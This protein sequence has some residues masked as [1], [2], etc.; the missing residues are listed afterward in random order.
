MLLGMNPE[1]L[2]LFEISTIDFQKLRGTK[3]WIM[4]A[5]NT[6]CTRRAYASGWKAFHSWCLAAGRES[7][8]TTPA[9]VTDFIAWCIDQQFRLA[10]VAV[11]LNAIGY[12]HRAAGSPSPIDQ[13]VREFMVNAKRKLKERPGGKAA[14]LYPILAELVA[15][16]PTVG[17]LA[18]R[19]RA[20]LLLTF[21]A[22]WRRSE[23]VTLDD[24][25]VKF[26]REGMEVYLP[27]SKT[28]QTAEGFTVGIPAGKHEN[29]CPV[30]AMKEWLKYRGAWQGPLFVR[31]TPC[32]QIA[33]RKRLRSRGE[34]LHLAVKKGIRSIGRNP[35]DFGAHSLRAGMITEAY[36]HGASEAA[37][38]KRTGHK[39]AST[40]QRYF[41]P[42]SAFSVDP[43]AAVL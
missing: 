30:R 29:T 23:I 20:M 41:R 2:L 28:D 13:S 15:T 25:D 18:I 43:L 12:Y 24:R 17:G 3:D 14:I 40:L 39:N 22:G 10:T 8:P 32:K 7:I 5:R 34:V 9:T 35:E 4:E 31:L 1:Q 11:R 6:L 26:V 19:N 37:I 33:T 36:Q 38:M 16:M 42:A 21:A 27:Y